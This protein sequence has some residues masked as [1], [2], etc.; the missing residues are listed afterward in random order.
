MTMT[1]R[2]FILKEMSVPKSKIYERI[3]AKKCKKYKKK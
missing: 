1:Q 2:M 3:N